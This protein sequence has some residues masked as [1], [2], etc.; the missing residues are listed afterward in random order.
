MLASRGHRA[1]PKSLRSPVVVPMP[2]GAQAGMLEA[3]RRTW[4]VDPTDIVW[5]D[6]A[7]GADGVLIPSRGAPAAPWDPADVLGPTSC[8]PSDRRGPDEG[9]GGRP[10][11]EGGPL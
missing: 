9:R 3:R 10:P 2:G 8:S 7:A 4:I 6:P 1:I 11:G 5:G